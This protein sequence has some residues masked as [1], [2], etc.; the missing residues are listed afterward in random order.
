VNSENAHLAARVAHLEAWVETAMKRLS[1]LGAESILCELEE[2][3]GLTLDD[4][5]ART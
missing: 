3:R 1:G 2:A 5:Q 4:M